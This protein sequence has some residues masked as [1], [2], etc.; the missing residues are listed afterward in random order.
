MT[1]SLT[2]VAANLTHRF[3]DKERR[4]TRFRRRWTASLR[5]AKMAELETRR[6]SMERGNVKAILSP[7]G[8]KSPIQPSPVE[9][10]G[11]A[12][13]AG[14]MSPPPKPH[15]GHTRSMT[16]TAR[17]S[18]RLSLNFP[19]QPLDSST[20]S[21]ETP[22]SSE[23]PSA[24]FHPVSELQR[25]PSPTEP[26]DSGEF[27]VELA[28]QERKVLELKEE[29]EKAEVHLTKLKRQ[30]AIHEANKK[31]A[32]IKQMHQLRSVPK[33]TGADGGF[34]EDPEDAAVRRSVELDRRRSLLTAAPKDSRRK[35]ITGGHT[36]ALSLLSPDR[37]T[38]SGFPSFPSVKDKGD[39]QE[40]SGNGLHRSSTIPDSLQGVHRLGPPRSRHSYQDTATIGVKQ[41]A[42]DLKAGIWTFMEDLRQATVGE[43]VLKTP[44]PNR[45]NDAGSGTISK[46]NSR[47]S[48]HGDGLSR[49]QSMSAAKSTTRTRQKAPERTTSIKTAAGAL[50]LAESGPKTPRPERRISEISG[51]SSLDDDWSN[52]DSPFTKTDSPRWS[53]STAPSSEDSDTATTSK[54]GSIDLAKGSG[55][56][57]AKRDEMPWPTLNNL[58]P[59]NLK[60]TASAIMKEWEKSL[61]P[62]AG[63]RQDPL[64]SPLS[65]SAKKQSDDQ[66]ASLLLS[67]LP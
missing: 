32:E 58:T 3:Q 28:A 8:N 22:T 38:Q 63:E 6:L 67:N 13:D 30:W 20:F 4:H 41:I 65:R 34:D 43:E 56:T 5:N 23:P 66:E 46:K 42:E 26:E 57:P 54:S 49:S 31:R 39:G 14:S 27:L 9:R 50:K 24:S 12:N 36:R 33:T 11:Q 48:I 55:F 53:G 7:T 35:I 37:M 25:T 40:P 29:L 10:I 18:N 60:R 59:S 45:T 44:P 47:N 52:W 2:R 15:R 64:G 1:I 21:R 17:N 62:P 19:I 16:F 61:S 51:A